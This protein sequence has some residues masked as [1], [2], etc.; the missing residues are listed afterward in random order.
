MSCSAA[1]ASANGIAALALNATGPAI[2][3]QNRVAAASSS[4]PAGAV[5][6][7]ATSPPV[8]RKPT[9]AAGAVAT[10]RNGC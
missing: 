4:A 9:R 3:V 2:A 7:A 5:A 10:V 8:N 1:T 6:G